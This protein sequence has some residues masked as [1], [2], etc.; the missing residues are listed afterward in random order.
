MQKLAKFKIAIIGI[1]IPRHRRNMGGPMA[2]FSYLADSYTK[3]KRSCK[4]DND[5]IQIKFISQAYLRTEPFKETEVEV[6]PI[7]KILFLLKF[8][9]S[10]IKERYDIINIQG[11]SELGGIVALIG[12]LMGSILVYSCHGLALIEKIQGR[13]VPWRLLIL[14]RIIVNLTDYVITVSN[15]FKKVIYTHFKNIKLDRIFVIYN[16]LD[17]DWINIGKEVPPNCYDITDKYLLFIGELS[18]NKGFDIL[19]QAF[20]KLKN[21]YNNLKM[22]VIGKDPKGKFLKILTQYSDSIINIEEVKDRNMLKNLYRCALA[23]VL[24]SRID[25]F[26]L[27]VIEAMSQGVPVVVS[28]NVGT[29][30]IIKPYNDGLIVKVGDVDDLVEKLE[31]IITNHELTSKIRE[32]ARKLATTLRWENVLFNYIKLYMYLIQQRYK[33]VKLGHQDY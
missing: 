27:T 20:F 5:V 30:E 2:V 4:L 19:L 31:M 11:I 28:R 26:P 1:Y 23:F 33:T 15:I 17:D 24:P 13:K 9:R 25:S 21:K 32:N 29:S 14:E 10:F 16:G 7:V 6:V 3:F 12:K 8:I 22:L 18:E